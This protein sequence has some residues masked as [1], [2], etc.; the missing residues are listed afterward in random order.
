MS[1]QSGSDGLNDDEIASFLNQEQAA[2]EFETRLQARA[3][4]FVTDFYEYLDTHRVAHALDP[5]PERND[6][7][8]DIMVG[9]MIEAYQC[10][11]LQAEMATTAW[12]IRE[13]AMMS[14]ITDLELFRFTGIPQEAL[15]S[16]KKYVQAQ[17]MIGQFPE[18]WADAM[19]AF[20]PGEPFDLRN[21]ADLELYTGLSMRRIEGRKNP[22]SARIA[23][24]IFSQEDSEPGIQAT[25]EGIRRMK[26]AP[27]VLGEVQKGY[28][29]SFIPT[30]KANIDAL[31]RSGDLTAEQAAAIHDLID[32]VNT[33]DP[34]DD[35]DDGEAA[36]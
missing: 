35:R 36:A 34:P 6:E 17:L 16:K 21:E 1:E 18:G 19:N 25:P 7:R 32:N 8:F 30:A 20:I 2:S 28:E 31:V 33:I 22:L 12:R 10:E 29:P 14:A 5:D 27:Q 4:G 23:E 26:L 11:P 3:D 9:R 15:T 13:K 24:I